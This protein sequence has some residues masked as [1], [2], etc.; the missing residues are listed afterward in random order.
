MSAGEKIQTSY[1]NQSPQSKSCLRVTSQSAFM[2]NGID[3]LV[4]PDRM[5]KARLEVVK[6]SV[7]KIYIT[8]SNKLYRRSCP[9]TGGQIHRHT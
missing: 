6:M 3:V 2:R 8:R 4:E 1:N 5:V 7:G 9:H